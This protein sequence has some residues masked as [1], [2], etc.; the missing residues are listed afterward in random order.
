MTVNFYYILT[1]N[2]SSIVTHVSCTATKSGISRGLIAVPICLGSAIR[3]MVIA[4]SMG[5]AVFLLV[6]IEG[7]VGTRTGMIISTRLCV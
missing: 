3:T 5:P 4:E 1:L 6:G 2:L 7:I